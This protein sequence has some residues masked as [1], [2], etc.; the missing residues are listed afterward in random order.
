MTTFPVVEHLVR[1]LADGGAG[2]AEIGRLLARFDALRELA[3]D[4]AGRMDRG[5]APSTAAATLKL[6]GTRFERD[7]L[8]V[9]RRVAPDVV[10]DPGAEGLAGLL[11]DGL[12]SAPGYTIRGG[13]S[14][15]L[16][17]ILGRAEVA[18]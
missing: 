3:W 5:E 18:G 6:L 4:V 7:V 17:R 11:A 13:T 9:A 10:P 8:E 1:R 16:L 14:E 12:L 2:A 15:V